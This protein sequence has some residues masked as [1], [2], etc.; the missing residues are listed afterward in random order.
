MNCNCIASRP[1]LCALFVVL[2]LLVLSSFDYPLIS[3]KIWISGVKFTNGGGSTEGTATGTIP[4]DQLLGGLLSPNFNEQSCVSRYQSMLYRKASPYILS[5]SLINKLRK[6]EELHK[7]CSPNTPLF[8]QSL[9]Q[10]KANNSTDQIKCNYVLW[11]PSGGLGNRMLAMVSTFLYALLTNRVMLIYQ[12]DDMVDLF[13][14]P[15]PGSTWYLPPDFPIKNLES[16]NLYSENS[17]G[18]MVEHNMINNDPN[19]PSSAVPSFIYLHLQ[20]D[21]LYHALHKRFFCEDD[22]EVINKINWVLLKLDNYIVPGLFMIPKYE[23]E[24]ERMFP[25][26]ET[27]FHHLGRYLFHPSNSVWGMVM[28]YH[29][30]Y[31]AKAKERIGIQARIFNSA[32]I[33]IDDLYKQIVTCTQDESILPKLNPEQSKNSFFVLNEATP[34]AVLLASLYGVLY[35]RLKNMYYLHSTTTSEIVS[36]YQPSHEENQQSEQQLHNQKALA[37]IWL[38]SFSDVLVT[39]AGSTFGYMAYSLAGIKPWFLMRS[40]DQKIPDPPCRRSVTI[41]PCFHSPPDDLICR[42]RNI[43]NAGKVVRHVRH[44]EDFNG[45]VKLFD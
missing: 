16:Y 13:C 4:N 11:T 7:K 10:L 12:V 29:N 32:P 26:K 38:L 19:S 24:L 8:H 9:Q 18:Y 2:S 41:D 36:V 1:L 34:R 31:M 43:T 5:S 23:K 15:F 21:Y 27:V 44:C 40:K 22:Q 42:T 3:S 14:E 35:D 25:I 17:Y 30:S 39:T 28:R 45:G 6:Y 20:Y 33:S 37:E